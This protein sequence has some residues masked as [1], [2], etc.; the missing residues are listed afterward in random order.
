MT[1]PVG[2]P[3]IVELR[4]VT[5]R[6]RRR[7]RDQGQNVVVAVDGVS[8]SVPAGQ[9]VA[10]VGESGAG[11]TT[12]GHLM[13]GLHRPD[14]GSVRFE[15]SDLASLGRRRLRQAR[16]RMHLVL[17]DPY[18]S[19]H[20]GMRVEAVVGE[21]LAI[22]GISRARRRDRV[23]SALEEVGLTPASRY[24]ARFPHQ[25]SG[26]QRQRVAIARAFVCEPRLVIAD[27]PTSM[28]DASLCAGIL[29]LLLGIRTRLG[30][31]FVYITHD[32]AV[33]RHVSD[34]LVVMRGGRILEDG[35]TDAVIAAPQH[36][37]TQLLLAASEGDFD[38]V[39][40]IETTG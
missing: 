4:D 5:K 16:R 17:Q 29:E 11:K 32:L 13:L 25:L 38:R 15:G 19:L 20:P 27:E 40:H 34:R 2:E 36:T 21:P 35:V 10:I 18:Q 6:F 31:A 39:E 9:V 26:G 14:L 37:Y 7:A 22:A 1:E 33:A 24:A 30:T 28:L 8:L 12:V 23:L 3:A